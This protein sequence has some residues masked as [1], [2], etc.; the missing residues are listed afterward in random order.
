MGLIDSPNYLDKSPVMDRISETLDRYMLVER[1]S[2]EDDLTDRSELSFKIKIKNIEHSDLIFNMKFD[3]DKVNLTLLN[4]DI[5]DIDKFIDVMI[6]NESYIKYYGIE[7]G[8]RHKNGYN[9]YN[10]I[11]SWNFMK[12]S[13]PSLIYGDNYTTLPHYFLTNQL[14]TYKI[15]AR[16]V[17]RK[18]NF[19]NSGNYLYD[20]YFDRIIPNRFLNGNFKDNIVSIVDGAELNEEINSIGSLEFD[21]NI[22]KDNSLGT[23]DFYYIRENIN[24][25][26]NG[27]VI[28]SLNELFE[29]EKLTS[30]VKDKIFD[31]VGINN[32]V[33]Q[34]TLKPEKISSYSIFEK[35]YGLDKE[36]YIDLIKL[37]NFL[38]KNKYLVKEF[39]KHY[40]FIYKNLN[41][42][43]SNL[44]ND[45][46]PLIF[47][48]IRKTRRPD[49][50]IEEVIIKDFM[51]FDYFTPGKGTLFF[52]SLIEEEYLMTK[53]FLKKFKTIKLFE[54]IKTDKIS[55]ALSTDF[56][57]S[58]MMLFSPSRL[59]E[60]KN[61]ISK[62]LKNIN[63]D[64]IVNSVDIKLILV[65]VSDNHLMLKGI[66]I[67]GKD[68]SIQNF[69]TR[70]AI[71]D[72]MEGNDDGE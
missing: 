53:D 57:D 36:A 45:I 58:L 26:R 8:N 63:T 13:F 43:G 46:I 54:E 44:Y 9:W 31:I 16:H 66:D 55:K 34:S 2:N 21:I 28:E 24:L 64:T 59:K 17:S 7:K 4:R 6:D 72:L 50:T 15:I 41:E 70:M 52:N 67:N 18:L 47:N 11:C 60:I 42:L 69:Y 33:M 39:I 20:N 32:T 3:E 30:S 71:I 49:D 5:N 27:I 10:Y 22:F 14:K 38:D 61:E 51:D 68:F 1:I 62:Y 48:I 35:I 40:K 29:F 65:K 23:I 12:D 19:N 25:K 56:I 37:N